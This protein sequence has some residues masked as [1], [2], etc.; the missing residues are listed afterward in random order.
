MRVLQNT[1]N[2]AETVL[3]FY[4]SF[5]SPCATDFSRT[6]IRQSLETTDNS[7]SLAHNL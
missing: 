3:V 1:A 6:I 7:T 4:F 2:E 5:I